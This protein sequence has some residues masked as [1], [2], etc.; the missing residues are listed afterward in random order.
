PDLAAHAEPGTAAEAKPNTPL[1]LP[2]APGHASTE[3]LP[4]ELLTPPC[5]AAEQERGAPSS[6]ITSQRTA[7]G[8]MLEA[9]SGG[10]SELAQ[11]CDKAEPQPA[12]QAG[13]DTQ[14]QEQHGP[15][16]AAA[17]QSS[18]TLQTPATAVAVLR[19]AQPQ[20]FEAQE[21][22]PER[23]SLASAV[24]GAHQPAALQV[25]PAPLVTAAQPVTATG[26][27][28]HEAVS[29][30]TQLVADAA[31][32]ETLA[33]PMAEPAQRP[34]CTL[35]HPWA[36]SPG[37]LPASG[38]VVAP[39]TSVPEPDQALSA[40]AAA[41]SPSRALP[42]PP[43][44]TVRCTQE[45]A[46]P[47]LP[48][49]T[50]QPPA[51]ALIR[52][53]ANRSAVQPSSS[54]PALEDMALNTPV[55]TAPSTETPIR[56][57]HSHVGAAAQG[58]TAATTFLRSERTHRRVPSVSLHRPYRS[59]LLQFRMYRLTPQY[60]ALGASNPPVTSPT[61]THAFDGLWPLCMFEVRGSCRDTRCP[62][63]HMQDGTLTA[64]DAALDMQARVAAVQAVMQGVSGS[65]AETVNASGILTLQG[66]DIKGGSGAGLTAV[67]RVQQQFAAAAVGTA[68]VPLSECAV[69]CGGAGLGEKLRS[70]GRV[71]FIPVDARDKRYFFTQPATAPLP[72]STPA[73]GAGA[74]K[75][76]EPPQGP[77]AATSLPGSP[78]RT[79]LTQP[80]PLAP[81][82]QPGAAAEAAA[83]ASVNAAHEEQLGQQG[84][85]A[86]FWL[87]WALELLGYGAAT[88][89]PV[90]QLAAISL[91]QRG[92]QHLEQQH[93]SPGSASLL[94]TPP[95]GPPRP[96][97]TAAAQLLPMRLSLVARHHGPG[98]H[99]DAV[100][101]EALAWLQAVGDTQGGSPVR[102]AAAY[103]LS[104]ALLSM[105]REWPKQQAIL[106]AG[107]AACL[108]ALPPSSLTTA[109]SPSTNSTS[110]QAE[111]PSATHPTP[112]ASGTIP[113]WAPPSWPTAATDQ[114]WA[115]LQPPGV[116]A[117]V[118]L[119]LRSLHL[120]AAA[121]QVGA[122]QDW[123]TQLL[124]ACAPDIQPSQGDDTGQRLV[125]EG[126]GSGVRE[127]R[128]AAAGAASDLS[129]RPQHPVH[130]LGTAAGPQRLSGMLAAWPS[131]ACQLWSAAACWASQG[132]LPPGMGLRLGYALPGPSLADAQQLWA[133]LISRVVPG[134]AAPASTTLPAGAPP[135]AE[136]AAGTAAGLELSWRCAGATLNAVAE[137]VAG[138][139]A[140]AGAG[141]GC[142]LLLHSQAMGHAVAV[143]A[144]SLL[145]LHPSTSHLPDR[146]SPQAPAAAATVAG[147]PPGQVVLE[148]VS[149]LQQAVSGLAAQLHPASQGTQQ[150]G[151]QQQQQQQQQQLS[152]PVGPPAPHPPG[153]QQLGAAAC[154]PEVLSA[155]LGPEASAR[156]CRALATLPS[157]T[158]E[159]MG[160]SARPCPT[161][162]LQLALSLCL[163]LLGA[164]L[165][166]HLQQPPTPAPSPRPPRT[167]MPTAGGAKGLS[168]DSAAAAAAAA[169]DVCQGQ[170]PPSS[171]SRDACQ[172]APSDPSCLHSSCRASAY[173]LLQAAV[174]LY[175]LG[176]VDQAGAAAQGLM[177]HAAAAAANLLAAGA[178]GAGAGA[179]PPLGGW[180]VQHEWLW[181]ALMASRLHAVHEMVAAQ[182]EASVLP[183][184][185]Q[186]LWHSLHGGDRQE[187]CVAGQS[188][189]SASGM[190]WEVS[191]AGTDLGPAAPSLRAAQPSS[192]HGSSQ[193]Q[194]QLGQLGP[195][196][197]RGPLH[198]PAPQEPA[199]LRSLLLH[200]AFWAAGLL[201]SMDLEPDQAAW[202]EASGA[203]AQTEPPSPTEPTESPGPPHP[204]TLHLLLNMLEVPAL[205]CHRPRVA[206]IA[207]THLAA[208][209]PHGPPRPP[210]GARHPPPA[211]THTH[212]LEQHQE[213]GSG[214]P[215]ALCAGQG[216]ASLGF[217]ATPAAEPG[218]EA[219]GGR[220]ECQGGYQPGPAA[221]WLHP[222]QC[223][224]VL[225]L[226][227]GL[228]SLWLKGGRAAGAA[229]WESFVSPGQQHQ[230]QR[231]EPQEQQLLEEGQQQQGGG[232]QQERPQPAT[233][234]AAQRRTL[235][236]LQP[237]SWQDMGLGLEQALGLG[238]RYLGH[239]QVQAW[240]HRLAHPRS[241]LWGS[242]HL[243]PALLAAARQLPA[244][245]QPSSWPPNLGWLCWLVPLVVAALV[246]S[247]PLAAEEVMRRKGAQRWA[248]SG[249]DVLGSDA[250][251]LG[252]LGG[253]ADFYPATL[254]L[255][256]SKLAVAVVG[257]LLFA[258]ALLLHR[259][260]IKIFLGS[261]RDIEQE[262]IKEKLSS[263]V[264]E[265]LLALT[266]F[267]E[268]FGAFFVAMFS[269]L[270]FV[271]VLHWLVQNRVDYIEV[272][273]T[274]SRLQH[275]RIIS[276]MSVLLVGVVE[277]QTLPIRTFTAFHMLW[278]PLKKS[279]ACCVP[280]QMI[281]AMFLSYTV[282]ATIAKGGHS[283]MLLFAFE[284]IIQASDVVRYFLKY[285]MSMVD[286]WLDG[287]WESKGTYVF[288]LE[289]VTDLLHL[290]VYIIFF[291]M[292]FT[293]Y[294]M[295]LH[296]VRDLYSAFRN[297]RKRI[298]D[299]LRFRQVSAR[300]N[301]LPDA[302]QADLER[303]DGVCIICREEMARGGANKKLMC[304]HVFHLHC[305]RSWLERQ[306]NCPTCRGAVFQR[307]QPP[308]TAAAPPAPPPPL[309][310][311]AAPALEVQ[312]QAAFVPPGGP[313]AAAPAAAGVRPGAAAAAGSGPS[314]QVAPGPSGQRAAGAGAG[315][316]GTHAS[317]GAAAAG[318]R[319]AHPHPGRTGIRVMRHGHVP[320]SGAGHAGAGVGAAYSVEAALE[321]SGLTA[322]LQ[323]LQQLQHQAAGSSAA[324]LPAGTS[325]TTPPLF[326]GFPTLGAN[327]LGSM[328]GMHFPMQLPMSG[329]MQGFAP[330]PGFAP[331][332]PTVLPPL[333]PG[334]SP[335][336]VVEQQAAAAAAAAALAAAAA[337]GAYNPLGGLIM[338]PPAFAPHFGS[339]ALHGILG[340]GSQHPP[341]SAATGPSPFTNSS[342]LPPSSPQPAAEAVSEPAT[343]GPGPGSAAAPVGLHGAG[344]GMDHKLAAAM[345]VV[346]ERQVEML[347]EQLAHIRQAAAQTS[348][349]TASAAQAGPGSQPGTA[350]PPGPSGQ[351]NRTVG[352]A[353]AGSSSSSSARLAWPP[354]AQTPPSPMPEIKPARPLSAAPAA[355]DQAHTPR[356]DNSSPTPPPAAA[357]A[358]AAPEA[359][360][361]QHAGDHN[362]SANLS[363]VTQ[364]TGA[365]HP[366]SAPALS[367]Q[368][369]SPTTSP[370]LSNTTR[371]TPAP[372]AAA[373][374][375]Q[376]HSADSDK[377]VLPEGGGPEAGP[378]ISVAGPGVL[379]P[380]QGQLDRCQSPE[381][382]FEYEEV[383]QLRLL[384]FLKHQQRQQQERQEQQQQEQQRQEQQEQ[385]QEQQGASGLPITSLSVSA[386]RYDLL[387][388][389][390]PTYYRF[391]TGFGP[392]TEPNRT[393]PNRTAGG[394]GM[395]WRVSRQH[396]NR[397][398]GVAVYLGAGNF[399]QG[400]W[401]AYV[402]LERYR[403]VV[404][405]P[406]RPITFDR[407]GRLV[408]VDEFRTSRVSLSVHARQPCELQ[409]PHD[410]PR[411][412][413]WVPPAGQ[414][415]QRLVRPAWSQRHPEYERGLSRCHEVPPNTPP[416]PPAQAPLA[417]DSPAPAL[418]Q[419][420]AQPPPGPVPRPQAPPWGTWLNRDTNGYLNFQNWATPIRL[421]CDQGALPAKGKEY[422]GLGYKRVRDK[423]P[424]A[425]KQQQQPAE[426]Q[427]SPIKPH[428]QPL[429]AASSAG[430]SLEANLKHITVTLA[431]WDAVWEVYLDPKWARQRLRLYGAQDR[432]L[433]QFFNKLEEEMAELSMER[434]NHA[435]Q[436][437]VFFG[438]ATI[439]TGGGWG[440]DAVLRACCK[441][442]CRPRGPDQR[443]GR[444]VLVDEHRTSR[445]SSAVND[446]QP[447]EEEL[448]KLS[449]TRPA[450]WKPPAGQVEQRLPPRKP[451]QAPRSSQSAT[452]PAASEPGPST[453]PP[454]KRSKP[455]AEPTKGKGKGKAAKAKP[456]PQPGRWLDRNCNAALNMQRIGESR[457][458][459]LELCYWP[460]QGALPAKGKEYPGLGLQAEDLPS[461]ASEGTSARARSQP[462]SFSDLL[463]P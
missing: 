23:R 423:P 292:V 22:A 215:P 40:A 457:W 443:R 394:E 140:G 164:H 216:A 281:D 308:A 402:V 429:A 355:H 20:V 322:L 91:L 375:A 382:G 368:S 174:D 271:K 359:S 89:S 296:L 99:L 60:T 78:G 8:D 177:L 217:T 286:L 19:E 49:A 12:Q 272:T 230:G 315:S 44:T 228:S 245:H 189:Q 415:N 109:T 100:K 416:P 170:G 163:L 25:P 450:G 1:T 211:S 348:P 160:A 455:A 74:I 303:S 388:D 251:K 199:H 278:A 324:P 16:P 93:P 279:K 321:A 426:A 398:R 179:F 84:G 419:P 86:G 353:A 349:A 167:Q 379:L 4:Q 244:P 453:P 134:D 365:P 219:P 326:P 433:E 254:Y 107:L 117:V 162:Q 291:G 221:S 393:E 135:A 82:L 387:P 97:S 249:S 26:Q 194:G 90:E 306:Q 446:K 95:A 156:C 106:Q 454:A 66:E 65:T 141:T 239:A 258:T 300:L 71:A 302:S 270:V 301:R 399:S 10:C 237:P 408:I 427:E 380:G 226:D 173:F 401:K 458:R 336:S 424:K 385:E 407:P 461:R 253:K 327:P 188:E 241:G 311:A 119:A 72:S 48:T 120:H 275:I 331:V 314:A 213:P 122:G 277:V 341:T 145:L 142:G 229:G 330:M 27:S 280:L 273:P 294:G 50:T 182:F 176:C 105:E 159:A 198:A 94:A 304:G 148:L 104:L 61:V 171:S 57:P 397:E 127:S 430:T 131:A 51:S 346:L 437:V 405:Q 79:S 202:S 166:H 110:R 411:P 187:G 83:I 123:L 409:L 459:P 338:M 5:P 309:E 425:Q 381:D 201:L 376:V 67:Q 392:R 240:V 354:P 130:L 126:Q 220:V 103:Q 343:A 360:G 369:P 18:P 406:S 435:K 378:S 319:V 62:R 206:A 248:S 35:G 299:F 361:P 351:V 400:G 54:V 73:S 52:I 442:V 180:G 21:P 403:N 181:A 325:Q 17:Q 214:L 255:S 345:Q 384:H 320:G 209:L 391:R 231:Q 172:L 147:Q 395:V 263:A 313:A 235:A 374:S 186:L 129:S 339:M 41:Q 58:Y 297:F 383:R 305:L 434:H 32:P 283:V 143:S 7:A 200:F 34:P 298:I 266:V 205:A 112:S 287:R 139:G 63:Q 45:A 328:P 412:G 70:R 42:L 431:T 373:D 6:D 310:A 358:A 396:Y 284:Y 432:A 265:S 37:M 440:A 371:H 146:P 169:R 30:L 149:G 250:G 356:T 417:Q 264:M 121:G 289:L 196:G 307:R 261:L 252:R 207:A 175:L 108:A 420:P 36:S 370:S 190:E 386:R 81:L 3:A 350:P 2:P 39:C 364:P 288:Y 183:H 243:A 260:V 421:S 77:P 225:C 118:D 136:A 293:N 334:P 88:A 184:H 451:P 197:L 448:N 236:V 28:P 445:V 125:A 413:D 56:P 276:F 96:A 178:V 53:A 389:P 285:A 274:V 340:G 418:D 246:A 366:A 242:P 101:E 318:I 113:H 333:V 227:P 312:A 223:S 335:T 456:A 151:E 317:G 323:H 102:L 332:F 222:V 144:A 161:S 367:A 208:L 218:G 362:S 232:R 15:S 238:L 87:Q 24:E 282:Q 155:W 452:Q 55:Q 111:A 29:P 157:C 64:L 428:L 98:P 14:G 210:Q 138:A 47:G 203:P 268:E 9:R 137:A 31:Q 168:G 46:V 92:S 344:L 13:D 185:P 115:P 234:V 444:V 377:A 68:G 154:L 357:A 262:M 193:V 212:G 195:G 329:G 447:C 414:V 363:T 76:S 460:D 132:R 165:L 191:E 85:C 436:L 390:D 38:P 462:S 233:A 352:E 224:L 290:F 133:E 116:Q 43:H 449:A 80:G 256:T 153:V 422:P 257:N 269:S 192:L 404:E 247:G 128:G 316:S 410:R 69:A 463:V 204:V 337:V 267:R 33:Q 342:G 372:G 114:A 59:P 347:Q 158:S 150:P 438:A 124:A 259:A 152:S 439:G 441:V 11:G 75:P 295:P